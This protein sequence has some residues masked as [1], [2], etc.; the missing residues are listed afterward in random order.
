MLNVGKG[1]GALL[2]DFPSHLPSRGP[3]PSRQ[4]AVARGTSGYG[5]LGT[6]GHF[7]TNLVSSAL[8]THCQDE[9]P[10]LCR[11][12]PLGLCAQHISVDNHVLKAGFMPSQVRWSCLCPPGNTPGD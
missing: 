7:P 12:H 5:L 11:R 2:R 4:A 6:W 9:G 1:F 8:V 10:S 3:R